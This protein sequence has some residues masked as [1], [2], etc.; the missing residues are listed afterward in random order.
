[1]AFVHA[2]VQQMPV[3]QVVPS[4]TAGFVHRPFASQVPAW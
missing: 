4:S 1:M 2:P 3:E